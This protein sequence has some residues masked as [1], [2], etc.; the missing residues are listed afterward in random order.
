[1]MTDQDDQGAR[2]LTSTE[3]YKGVPIFLFQDEH[4]APDEYGVCFQWAG[5]M[6]PVEVEDWERP[7][8]MNLLR[9]A[10]SAIDLIR[11]VESQGMLGPDG[12]LKAE[13]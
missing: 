13:G 1:M 9:A 10:R 5:R 3:T 6:I 12:T 4:M 11:E 7:T 8:R 2:G